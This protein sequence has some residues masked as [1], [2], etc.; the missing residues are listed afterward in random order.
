[1]SKHLTIV[2]DVGNLSL[3][4]ISELIKT[5]TVDHI[6]WGHAVHELKELKNSGLVSPSIYE[7]LRFNVK[8]ALVE[9]K[10]LYEDMKENGLSASTIEA[11][12][13]LRGILTIYNMFEDMR[14]DD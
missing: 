3:G 11:E 5:D 6:Y 10:E 8:R 7:D 13:Y 1:M 9:A 4:S 2:H 12:G 14:Y